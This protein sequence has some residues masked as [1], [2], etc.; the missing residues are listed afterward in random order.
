MRH[1]GL[2]NVLNYTIRIAIAIANV[3][4]SLTCS[5]HDCNAQDPFPFPNRHNA[6]LDFIKKPNAICGYVATV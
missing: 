3:G 1:G 2:L 4:I 6:L 5:A